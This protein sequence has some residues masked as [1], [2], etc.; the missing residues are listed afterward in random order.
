MD[1]EILA[2]GRRHWQH[3]VPHVSVP[4]PAAAGGG[5][6]ALRSGKQT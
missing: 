3:R 5:N 4:H 1:Q 6:L 2:T